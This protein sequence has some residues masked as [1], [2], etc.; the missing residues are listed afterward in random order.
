MH[1]QLVLGLAASVLLTQLATAQSA[2]ILPDTGRTVV[3]A[4]G[5]A[6]Q[7]TILDRAAL[8]LMLD[9][10]GMTV[11]DATNRLATIERGVLDTLRRFNLPTRSVHSFAGGVAPYRPQ[12]ISPSM[13]GGPTFAGRATIR[14][15]DLRP[16]QLAPITAA[17]LAK[18]VTNI[19]P[20]SFSSSVADSLRR[21]LVPGAFAQA[22]REAES[23]A[24]A[25]GGQ[26]G[27]LLTLSITPTPPFEQQQ[28]QFV[29]PP[30]FENSP[31]MIP[32][33][34]L[35]VNVSASWILVPGAKQ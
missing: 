23:V 2:G 32:N 28:H 35:T 7:P 1:S 8:V 13:M 26:L 19:A 11:E 27:R 33:T 14:I 6:R 21:I 29:N 10:Q 12:N 30:Y 18:G 34:N 25:A 20:P 24:R 15:E 16:E 31:R 5:Q 17:V 9:A 3:Y 4:S 22:K